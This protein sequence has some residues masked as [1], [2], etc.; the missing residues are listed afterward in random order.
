[1]WP[2]AVEFFRSTERW[3]RIGLG[4]LCGFGMAMAFASRS[5]A[6]AYAGLAIGLA[7]IATARASRRSFIYGGIAGGI[8]LFALLWSQSLGSASLFAIPASVS[9]ASAADGLLGRIMDLPAFYAGA[10]GTRELGWVDTAM[11]WITWILAGSAFAMTMFWGLR[12]CG[13]RKAASLLVVLAVGSAVPV[14][15]ATARQFELSKLQPRYFLPLVIIGAMI[16]VSE[17]NPDGPELNLVQALTIPVALGLAQAAALHANLRRYVTGV[18]VKA[19]NL[20]AGVEWW[21]NW[22]P[23]PMVVLAVGATAFLGAVAVVALASH[24]QPEVPMV[25]LSA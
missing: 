13:R 20:D 16:A 17:D 5:D 2:S 1:V 14:L 9:P 15:I 19:F 18:D 25:R 12:R 10:F 24:S 8:I 6:A 3:R 11:P 21:W 7:W 22:A 23:S 4:L